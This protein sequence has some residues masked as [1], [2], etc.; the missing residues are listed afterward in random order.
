MNSFHKLTNTNGYEKLV[1]LC[2]KLAN[3]LFKNT[4]SKK[5]KFNFRTHTLSF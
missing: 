3:E 2:F 1:F 5:K 4:K